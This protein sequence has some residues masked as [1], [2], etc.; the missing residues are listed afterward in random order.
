MD[1]AR[2]APRHRAV[3][4]SIRD[5]DVCIDCGC[6]A[7]A[8]A[9][10]FLSKGAVTYAFEPHP[11]LSEMLSKKYTGNDKMK[12]F[13]SAVWDR[14][15]R[16]DLHVQKV[17]GSDVVN[18]EGTTLFANRIDARLE[19]KCSVEVIDLTEFIISLGKRVKVLKI[20]VEG[21]EF[22]IIDKIID[23]SLHERIDH[24]FCETHPHFFPDGADRLVA[25]EEKIKQR[26][27][28]NIHLDWV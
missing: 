2:I 21:A 26:K 25:L 6:N 14:Y 20:D 4:E 7:G 13:N 10:I 9:D 15:T 27:I 12:V 22:E 18:L 23:T 5:Q 1:K 11:Y 24:V 8:V 16:M 3:F 28:T 19:T 17:K